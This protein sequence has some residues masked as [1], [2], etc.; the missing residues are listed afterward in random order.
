MV[1]FDSLRKLFARK[2]T[3]N[4]VSLDDLRHE[5]ARLEVEERRYTA[6]IEEIEEEKK[7]LFLEGSNEASA[8]KQLILARKIKDRDDEIKNMNKNLTFFS[9]QLRVING[10]VQLKENQRILQQ[11]GISAII[12]N[13]DLQQLQVY[14]DDATVDGVFHMDK[15]ND[16]LRT[17][18]QAGHLTTPAAEDKDIMDIVRVMQETGAALQQDPEALQKG[19]EKVDKH[20]T[21]EEPEAEEA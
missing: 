6:R 19:L 8:T 15:F 2:K 17:L 14:V 4:D 20:L 21:K 3:L 16:I 5:K 10:F 11:S 1:A 13:V 9:R 7:R 18:D 12:T